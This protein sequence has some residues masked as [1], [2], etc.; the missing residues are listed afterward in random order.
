[1]MGPVVSGDLMISKKGVRYSNG[2]TVDQSVCGER[3][4]GVSVCVRERERDVRLV[5][6]E[7]VESWCLTLPSEHIAT[8]CFEG[9]NETVFNFV[10]LQ[11]KKGEG[12]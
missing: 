6:R 10:I 3:W 4:G 1:M 5:E 12:G 2:L 7:R 8:K 11:G 9:F